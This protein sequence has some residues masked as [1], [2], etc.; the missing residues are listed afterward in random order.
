[1]NTR[2]SRLATGAL[3]AVVALVAGTSWAIYEELGPSKDDWKMKYEI[4]VT[5]AGGN[6]LSVAFTL[7]DEGRLKPVHSVTVIVFSEPDRSGARRYELKEKIEL[8]PTSDGTRAGQ[9]QIHKD[10]AERAVVRVLATRVDGRPRQGASAAY[11][12]IPLKK[13]MR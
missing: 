10:F 3:F 12:D 9:V 6:A 4:Q 8:K 5:P 7:A 2:W 11:Y 13:F 1:V